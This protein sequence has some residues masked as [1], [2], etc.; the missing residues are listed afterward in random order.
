[1]PIFS[2][3]TKKIILKIDD[4]FDIVDEGLLIFKEGVKNYLGNNMD[5]FENQY[6]HE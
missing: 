3:H 5:L 2:R 6:I 4:F 1:M